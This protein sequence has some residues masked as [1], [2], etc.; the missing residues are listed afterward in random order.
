MTDVKKC[1]LIIEQVFQDELKKNR[2][3]IANTILGNALQTIEID[4]QALFKK[5][6]AGVDILEILPDLKEERI[7]NLEVE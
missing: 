2:G 4:I 6:E 5:V 1:K 3:D 7:K